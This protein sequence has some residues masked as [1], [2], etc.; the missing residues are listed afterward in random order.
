MKVAEHISTLIP[1][2]QCASRKLTGETWNQRK[3]SDSLEDVKGS[4][5]MSTQHPCNAGNSVSSRASTNPTCSVTQ[6]V[7]GGMGSRA[8]ACPIC[9]HPDP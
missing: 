3:R 6:I 4:K 1:K 5:Q 8:M 9:Q 2:A 7:I